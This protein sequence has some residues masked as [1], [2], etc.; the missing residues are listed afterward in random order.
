MTLMLES[1]GPGGVIW[2][3]EGAAEARVSTCCT[4]YTHLYSVPFVPY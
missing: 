3:P 2:Q 1:Q 4:L